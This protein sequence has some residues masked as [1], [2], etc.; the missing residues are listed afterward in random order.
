MAEITM[1]V[2]KEIIS[3]HVAAAVMEA[4]GKDPDALIKAVVDEAMRT[5]KNSY[6]SDTIFLSGVKE[7]IRQEANTVFK[8][9]LEQKRP[10]IQKAILTRLKREEAGF[11]NT[12]A[13][14]LVD[15]MASSFYVSVGLRTLE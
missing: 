5:K 7:L 3:A 10:I 13:D 9:W 2:P 1:Q 8:D 6:E 11:I 15:G 4:L 12:V 14:K